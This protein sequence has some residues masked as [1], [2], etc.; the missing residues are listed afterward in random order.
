MGARIASLLAIVAIATTVAACGNSLRDEQGGGGGGSSGTQSSA[1]GGKGITMAGVFCVCF[2]NTY[3]AWKRGFFEK[4]G[5]PV[6]KFVT[7]KA[8]ADTFAALAGGNVDFGL[9]GLDAIIRGREKGVDVRSV[10]TVSPEFYALTVRKQ[11]AGDI[12][13]PEDLKGRK[14][15]VSKVGSASWAFLQLLMRKGGLSEGDVKVVQL[16]AIDTIM[17]GLKRGT[18]DAAITWEPG[19]SQA[20]SDGSAVPI[21]NSLSPQDH[22]EIYGTDKSINITL[23]TTDK[24]IDKNSDKVQRVVR[25]LNEADAWIASHSPEQ[26]ADAIAPVAPGI[27][28]DLL[29]SAVKDTRATAPKSTEISKTAY[30]SSAKVLKESEIIKSVPPLNEP[31]SCDFAKCTG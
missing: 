17:A 11:D 13:G 20:K 25:A 1:T 8:G 6:K 7:T 26:V 9:S 3:V 31:F 27:D 18:V 12:Q 19:T 24:M 14:V 30:E 10:A 4:E 2:M 22:Q 21:V 16:G 15:A 23:A 28:R 5:V 29:V